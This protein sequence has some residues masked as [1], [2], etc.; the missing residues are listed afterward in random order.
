MMSRHVKKEFCA[1]TA[2]QAAQELGY[3]LTL[4]TRADAGRQA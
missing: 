1:F 2:H 4:V 3:Q